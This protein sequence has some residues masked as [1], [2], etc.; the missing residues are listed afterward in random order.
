EA[1][2]WELQNHP[3][4]GEKSVFRPNDV[5][6]LTEGQAFENI[7]K[8]NQEYEIQVQYDFLGDYMLSN[9]TKERILKEMNRDMPVGFRVKESNR[10]SYYYWRGAG[11]IDKRIWY[12]L[13]VITIIYFICSVLLESL[14]QALV[15][16]TIAPISFI[17]CFLGFYFFG[18]TFNEGGLAAFIMMCGLSVNAILYIINDYNNKVKNGSPRGLATYL[19]A[20]NAKIIPIL[21]TIVSTMLGFIPFL[22]GEISDFWFSLAVGTMSGLAFSLL[23]LIGIL[24]VMFK[25]KEH[26]SNLKKTNRFHDI[27]H[28]LNTTP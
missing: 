10:W 23:V 26:Q 27:K 28:Q 3:L 4:Q 7:A 15:V 9:K 6:N 24:P 16:I 11:G 5:G 12:I 21:L 20:Y 2:L 19:R 17:G 13:L 22:I 25:G 14:K 8:S 18:L 1:I